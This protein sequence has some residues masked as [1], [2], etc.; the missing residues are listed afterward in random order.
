MSSTPAPLI[1]VNGDIQPAEKAMVSAL[2]RGFLFGDN[3]FET[4]VGFH[5]QLLDLKPHLDRL[6]QSADDLLIDIPWSDEALKFEMES[7]AAQ[8]S[9]PKIFIRLVITR[10][11]GLGL[12]TSDELAPNKMLYCFPAPVEK[13]ELYSEGISL[14]RM[15]S[16]TTDRGPSA[17][18]GNYLRS[19]VAIKRAERS[20]MNDILWTN[21]SDELTEASTAN[22]FFIGREGD[23][24]IIHTPSHM[25]GILKGITRETTMRLLN[26]AQ[27]PVHENVIYADEL[28]RYDE[29]FLC[30]TI[31]GL[32]PVVQI[33]KQKFYTT[34]TNSIFQHINRLYLSWAE[35]ELGF[36]V[37]WNTGEKV[38]SKL[39]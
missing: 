16:P 32:V 6:R 7:L 38:P 3:I 31:K 17:K 34:R 29:A 37:D 24:V 26:N 19:I 2:D 11:N 18:T 8:V 39:S 5:G 4:L 25:S 15:V 35:S 21:S 9:A 23:S 28:A 30:S 12:K 33:D 1:S 20:G 27:I 10:G 36:R 13:L 22:I 14:K